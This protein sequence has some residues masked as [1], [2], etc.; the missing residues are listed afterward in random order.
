LAPRFVD[1]QA[2]TQRRSDQIARP[3]DFQDAGLGN[4]PWRDNHGVATDALEDRPDD[5]GAR[6]SA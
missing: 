1:L 6:R 5:N 4:W 3:V 2:V